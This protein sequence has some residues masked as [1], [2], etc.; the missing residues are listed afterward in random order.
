MSE[1]GGG[2]EADRGG[3]EDAGVRGV[4]GPRQAAT[5]QDGGAEPEEDQEEDQ[6]QDLGPGEQ[7]EEERVHGQ[8]RGE[9]R[10]LQQRASGD[11]TSLFST[12]ICLH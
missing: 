1:K 7:T 10:A 5:L 6:E 12:N 8:A 9:V 4:Q 2:S 11:L 3:E